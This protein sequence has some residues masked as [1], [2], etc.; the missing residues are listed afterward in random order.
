MSRRF[1]AA[2]LAAALLGA[3]AGCGA[4]SREDPAGAADGSGGAAGAA[5]TTPDIG[6][7]LARAAYPSRFEGVELT[8]T[9]HELRRQGR[10]LHLV[11]SVAHDGDEELSLWDFDDAWDVALVDSVNLRRHSVVADGDQEELAPYRVDTE[12]PVGAAAPLGYVFAAPP[13]DV[14]AM[15]VYISTFP[16]FRDVPVSS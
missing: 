5:G 8:L 13:E 11:Y 4:G 1:G 14:T 7:E 15:D 9:V 10:L 6:T 3:L 16:P 2:V 12:I